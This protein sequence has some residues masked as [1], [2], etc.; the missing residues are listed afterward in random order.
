[1]LAGAD[2][3][4]AVASISSNYA[5][6]GYSKS[7]NSPTA[8]INVDY[9]H[10]SGVYGGLWI[11]RV[12]FNDVGYSDRSNVEFYP[13]LGFAYS[14][15]ADWHV[16]ASLARYAFDGLIFGRYSDYNEYSAALNFRDLLT[17]KLNFADNGY[18]RGGAI[19]NGEV[20]GRYP[21]LANLDISAGIAYNYVDVSL[22][23]SAL[24]W[25]LGLTWH[26]KH[27]A[28][29]VRYVDFAEIPTSSSHDLGPSLADLKQNFLGSVSIGF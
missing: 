12:D 28:L 9:G 3:F 17:V 23:D 25:N 19:L 14:L 5:Y 11:S 10:G 8:R 18:H 16:E 21:I 4:S 26:Y 13:Y 7:D 2:G 24:Y 29:D 22:A 6:R 27:V 20:T 1:M 15:A